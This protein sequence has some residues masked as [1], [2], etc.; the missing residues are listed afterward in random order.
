MGL[1]NPSQEAA[2]EYVASANISGPLAQQIKS[3]LHE[4]PDETELHAAQREMCQVKNRYLK[5][6]LDQV[7]DS[8]SG[9]TLRAVD[10]AT[11]KGASSWLTV[12]PIRDMNFDL[13]KT[14]FRDAV[15]L[16][17]GWDV[18]D[19]PPVCVCG[20]HFNVDHAMICKRGGFVIQRHNELRDLEAEML[21]MV[22][23]GVETEPILQ[24][25][26]GEELNRGAI[27]APDARLD[28]VA[29]GFWERQRSAFVDVR[30]CHPNADS[31]R[32]MDFYMKLRRSASTLVEF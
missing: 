27:T 12:L 11:Q 16:R 30:I 14:E 21:R 9:K 5:E 2:S 13:N 18:P 28:I 10:L 8:V 24:D 7:K 1:T 3:Q 25:I 19:M 22:C 31:Y 32:D 29:R 17:Y 6:K 20:D 26:T 23:N 15:K 4:P